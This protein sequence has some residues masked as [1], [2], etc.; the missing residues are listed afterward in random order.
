[1]SNND[2][3]RF[4]IVDQATGRKFCVETIHARDERATDRAFVNG[5]T[6]GS[7][8]KNKSATSGGSISESESI[9][10]EDNGF[11][12]IHTFKG[13]PDGFVSWLLKNTTPQPPSIK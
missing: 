10:T 4:Y 8:V 5:G 11:T 2:D 1:M 7:A 3:G 13:S 9:I 12:N 6:D